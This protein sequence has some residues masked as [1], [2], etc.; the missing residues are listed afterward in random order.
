MILMDIEYFMLACGYVNYKC[1]V[2][3]SILLSMEDYSQLLDK[4]KRIQV[5]FPESMLV[6]DRQMRQDFKAEIASRIRQSI[7][8]NFGK[9]MEDIPTGFK[10]KTHI[11]VNMISQSFDFKVIGKLSE[12]VSDSYLVD[13]IED[14]ELEP[15]SN[16]S[17]SIKRP[18]DMIP[19]LK[20]LLMMLNRGSK[21]NYLTIENERNQKHGHLKYL[22]YELS[23]KRYMPNKEIRYELI[24]ELTRLWASR[25]IS[26]VEYVEEPSVLDDPF[27]TSRGIDHSKSWEEIFKFN[28]MDRHNHVNKKYSFILNGTIMDAVDKVIN[29][30]YMRNY[31]KNIDVV[32]L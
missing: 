11:D 2:E 22:G 13:M 15:S 27:F 1:I 28:T 12:D 30:E 24:S 14:N 16:I 9:A 31:F 19:D 17:I 25:E 26:S 10:I 3:L 29:Y 5:S 20:S 18:I 7:M 4:T 21:F 23:M 32:V 6:A 8:A